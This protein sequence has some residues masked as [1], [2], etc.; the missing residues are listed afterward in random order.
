MIRKEKRD[1]MHY[2]SLEVF[3]H[4]NKKRIRK[5]QISILKNKR[6]KIALS[7]IYKKDVPHVVMREE[8]KITLHYQPLYIVDTDGKPDIGDPINPIQL[9]VNKNDKT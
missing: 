8:P 1:K 6:R 2:F 3:I 9:E 5:R 7:G 4:G